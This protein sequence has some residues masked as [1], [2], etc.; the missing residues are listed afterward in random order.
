VLRFSD[1]I[2][3]NAPAREQLGGFMMVLK[4]RA[5]TLAFLSVLV[6]AVMASAA[7]AATAP[8]AQWTTGSHP[9]AQWTTGTHPAV[10]WSSA[11]RPA[12]QWTTRARLTGRTAAR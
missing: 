9:A 10:S 6:S 3:E 1:L 2:P 12:A 8:A 7:S 5:V 11:T 4:K